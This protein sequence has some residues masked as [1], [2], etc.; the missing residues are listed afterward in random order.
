M[1]SVEHEMGSVLHR[2]LV[3]V[4]AEIRPVPEVD[5]SRAAQRG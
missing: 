1:S 4:A 2:L 5:V 3:R